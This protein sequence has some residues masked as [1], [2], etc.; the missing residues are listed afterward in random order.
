MSKQVKPG[1]CVVC[2]KPIQIHLNRLKGNKC[3]K[4]GDDKRE[5]MEKIKAK[6]V[7]A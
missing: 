3:K 2:G 6:N 7:Q 1:K 5:Y 4:C